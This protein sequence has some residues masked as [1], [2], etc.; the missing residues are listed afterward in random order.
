MLFKPT[1]AEEETRRRIRE[2][3]TMTFAEFMEVA[4][5]WPDGGYYSTPPG[6]RSGG[7]L[8]YGAPHTPGLR[9]ADCPAVGDDVAGCWPA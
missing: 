7:G 9:G 1:G 5:Y 4:L 3:G 6:V 8:L 2:R